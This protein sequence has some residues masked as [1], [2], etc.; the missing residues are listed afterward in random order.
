MKKTLYDF[1]AETMSSRVLNDEHSHQAFI[2]GMMMSLCGRYDIKADFENG[3]GYSDITMVRKKGDSPNIIIELKRSKN[4]DCLKNDAQA[5]LQQ[6]KDMDYTH[7][8]KEKTILC[9]A[10]F[11]GKE[12]F[13]SSEEIQ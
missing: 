2:T 7:G 12:P 5:A 4:N 9:G 10:A 3:R 1:I 6:I 8:L 13:I 11:S